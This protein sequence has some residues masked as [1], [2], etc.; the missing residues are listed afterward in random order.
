MKIH[1]FRSGAA[2]TRFIPCNSGTPLG[3]KSVAAKEDRLATK[4]DRTVTTEDRTV[5][6]EDRTVTTE[7]RTVTKED[8]TVTKKDRMG[9]K[10]DCMVTKKD[11]MG[12]KEDRMGMKD[13][14][15]GMKKDCTGTKDDRLITKK[16]GPLRRLN[17]WLEEKITADQRCLRLADP[18]GS[19]LQSRRKSAVS[20]L[21]P[22]PSGAAP[23]VRRGNVHRGF[24]VNNKG[25]PTSRAH[26]HPTKSG[27]PPHVLSMNMTLKRRVF[28]LRYSRVAT[29]FLTTKHRIETLLNQQ[30]NSTQDRQPRC[31]RVS[32]DPPSRI[33]NA[34]PPPTAARTNGSPEEPGE[35]SN[36]EGLLTEDVATCPP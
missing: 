25:V 2:H 14:C 27:C 12:T 33:S 17:A 18:R 7:D 23:S 36:L 21:G 1:C 5:T 6:K 9:T 22:A 24:Q 29:L 32:I 20:S 13:D 4:D 30:L 31:G 11:R 34:R 10:E 15:A 35:M 16:N 28:Q 26:G 8:R 19:A 3:K